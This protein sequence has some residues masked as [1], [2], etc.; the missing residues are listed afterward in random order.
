MEEIPKLTEVIKDGSELE[1]LKALQTKLATT[2]DNT[3]SAR[4]LAALS[5]QLREVTEKIQELD[6]LPKDD[7]E[8][9][10]LMQKYK[11]KSVRTM[12]GQPVFYTDE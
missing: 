5:R 4:D 3:K 11:N 9:E 2:I 8:L 7:D 10:M 6:A 1:I 12:Q